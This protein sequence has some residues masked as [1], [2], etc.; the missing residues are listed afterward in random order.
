MEIFDN[1]HPMLSFERELW[2]GGFIF[3]AGVDEAGRG[4]LAGS[5]V[6][7]AVI[8]SKEKS[9]PVVN[10]SKKLTAKQRDSLFDCIKKSAIKYSIVEITS[11]EIDRINILQATHK[12]MREAVSQLGIAQYALID[13]LPVS[14]MPVNSKAIVKGDSKSASIAAASILAKVHRDNLMDKYAQLYPQYGFERN[15]GYGTA[16]HI[17]AIQ[18]Y[19]I[20]PIHRK[21][22]EPI[23]SILEKDKKIQ[24]ELNLYLG[25]R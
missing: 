24:L 5:V 12:G 21:T 22:F 17:A 10:D 16:K 1:C 15:K 9:I 7:S 19:G 25:D 18:K 14:K 6:V 23:K 20:S 8:F 2:D 11:E 13:G 3:V 4:P